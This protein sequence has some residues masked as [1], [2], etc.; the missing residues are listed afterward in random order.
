MIN[1]DNLNKMVK[2]VLLGE[3]PT[4]QKPLRRKQEG[5]DFRAEG[6]ASAKALRLKLNCVF[7]VRPGGTVMRIKQNGEGQT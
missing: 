3:L 1:S 2:K 5:R 7:K 6:T 4:K